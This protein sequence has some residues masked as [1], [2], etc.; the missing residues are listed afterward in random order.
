M[1]HLKY[2]KVTKSF[3]I[4]EVMINSF[5]AFFIFENHRYHVQIVYTYLFQNYIVLDIFMIGMNFLAI[6]V[7][8][9]IFI[10]AQSILYPD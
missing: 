6:L 5:E 2:P 4:V 7:Y 10:Y 3:F 8:I 9:C 1:L